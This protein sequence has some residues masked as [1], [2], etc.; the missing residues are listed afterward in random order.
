MSLPRET[1]MNYPLDVRISDIQTATTAV[2]PAFRLVIRPTRSKK[3]GAW[4]HVA[5]YETTILLKLKGVIKVLSSINQARP[6]PTYWQAQEDMTRDRRCSG[7]FE[8]QTG[9]PLTG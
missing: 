6:F 2:P 7:E 3:I 9:H 4:R 5:N 8:H 1:M